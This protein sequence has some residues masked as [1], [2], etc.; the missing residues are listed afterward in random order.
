[1]D[2]G[3]CS[4][5]RTLTEEF[6]SQQP[7]PVPPPERAADDSRE[8]LELLLSATNDGFVDWD[9]HT[10]VARYSPRWKMLLGYEEHELDETPDL[11][12]TLSHP[13]DLPRIE[14]LMR[15]HIEN[16]WP[17]SDR[18]RM[19]HRNGDWRWM[20][21]RSVIIHDPDGGP[22]RAVS[23]YTDI[24][25]QVRAEERYRALA[26]GI[27]D[28]ILRI[29]NDGLV[30]DQKPG[31]TPL[32]LIGDDAIGQRLLEWSKDRAWAE[33]TL[34][35]VGTVSRMGE[36]VVFEHGDG[37]AGL[38]VEIRVVKSG[39]DEAVCIAR[40]ITERK[41]A[42]RRLIDSLDRL[43]RAQRQLI[44]TSHRAGMAEVASSVLHNVG[45]VLNSVNVSAGAAREI[46]ETSHA[47][48]LAKAVKL[49]RDHQTDL[50]HF[51]T[52]DPK[53]MKVLDF[54]ERLAAVLREE[55]TR[56]RGELESLQKNID[57]IKVIV[58]MQQ[59]HARSHSGVT[60][61]FAPADVVEDAIKLVGTWGSGGIELVREL[62]ELPEV[63]ADRH[64]LL[65]ILTNL[66]S[67]A[68]QALTDSPRKTVTVR[69][70]PRDRD[71]FS[72]EVE[73]SGA[74]ITEENRKKIFQHGFTTRKEGHGFGLHSSALAAR[75]MGGSVAAFSDGPGHGARF[76]VE[77]PVNASP[78]SA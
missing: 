37:D 31:A 14:E 54:L 32:D 47:G 9:L 36:V 75:S 22:H 71:R 38:C 78:R 16:V 7:A 23:V 35:A 10:G 21:C 20:L 46:V 26:N 72:I 3:F 77:L 42:E 39:E 74:G 40:D 1:M 17:F 44:E 60:E 29:R 5:C 73:D 48:G 11:W 2:A 62:A 53:G 55:G 13:G 57:H 45:N 33:K 41:Q 15:D 34:A 50:G 27:P 52:A 28:A 30:L 6:V 4:A 66:L 49:L 65:Q 25:D 68:R 59:S 19:R 63:D 8:L 51:L 64:K 18:W 24:T 76:V 67:N 69:L 58:S 61:R 12:K 56:V 43:S 70:A